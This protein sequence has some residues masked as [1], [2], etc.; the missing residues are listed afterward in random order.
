[1]FCVYQNKRYPPFIHSAGIFYF[2]YNTLHFI[3]K[4]VFRKD[5]Y[6]ETKSKQTN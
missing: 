5:D 1:M 3:T 4:T 2:W 6:N